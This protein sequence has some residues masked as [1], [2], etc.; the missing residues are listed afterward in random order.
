MGALH[1][2]EAVA[3]KRIAAARAARRHPEVLEAVRR[4]DLHVTGVSLLAPQLTSG[5]GTELIEAARH[6]TADEIRRLLADR[7]PKPDVPTSVRRLPTA[8]ALRSP[9]PLGS[10]SATALRDA[11]LNGAP[12][13]EPRVAE[14]APIAPMPPMDS[15]TDRAHTQPLGGERYCVRFAAD[16]ELHQQLQELR[17]LMRHQVP[18]GDI[19]RILARAVSVLLEQVRKRKFGESAAPRPA[20]PSKK[21]G[22]RHVPVAIRRAVAHRDSG[23][24]TYVSPGGRRCGGRE[25]LEFHHREPWART[26]AD[27]VEG[28][29][30][31]CRAHNQ[32][33]ACRD[34]GQRHMA[35]F[36][37]TRNQPNTA[38]R[39][40]PISRPAPECQ[41]DLDPVDLKKLG[42]RLASRSAQWECCVDQLSR[43]ALDF[44]PGISSRH[45]PQTL[46][47]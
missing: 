3:Y 34:F 6:K 31:H 12:G 37:K 26:P 5:N 46:G 18:D 29:A 44:A 25:F 19:A 39:E 16:P 45:T 32:Y 2:A 23:G 36:G 41:Q 35:R 21:N 1:F 8:A 7:Q 27:A 4:G 9:I 15:S 33:E 47:G 40:E 11:P 43:S 38:P 20:G 42:G 28:I 30:L 24:C 22:A 10:V 13:I 14:T 17:A